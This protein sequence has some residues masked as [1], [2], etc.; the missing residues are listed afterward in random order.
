MREKCGTNLGC[1]LNFF[2]VSCFMYCLWR[3]ITFLVLKS[4]KTP[5]FIY[6]SLREKSLSLVCLQFYSFL[7]FKDFIYLFWERREGRGKERDRNIDMWEKHWLV[8]SCIPP[9][10]DWTHNAGMFPSWESNWQPFTLWGHNQLSYAS[11]G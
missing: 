4:C 11:Q 6:R 7:F 8:A 9:N 5:Y 1:F 10:G 2:H 3:D